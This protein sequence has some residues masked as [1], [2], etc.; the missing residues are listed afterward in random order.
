MS[1]PMDEFADAVKAIDRLAE[2]KTQWDNKL[3]PDG[4]FDWLI[5][6]V[7]RLQARIK[8]LERSK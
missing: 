7:E 3:I 6:E 1:D 8:V 2:I 5:K 4:S